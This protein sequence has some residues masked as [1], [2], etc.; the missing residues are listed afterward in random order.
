MLKKENIQFIHSK[1]KLKSVAGL[2]VKSLVAKPIRLIFT[3]LLSI[4][5]FAMFGVFDAVGSFNDERAVIAL[6]EGDNYKSVSIYAQYNG[7]GYNEAEFKLSQAQINKINKDTKYSF[8]G[9]YDIKDNA[10]YV[11]GLSQRDNFNESQTISDEGVKGNLR[12]GGDYYTKE[13][14]GIIEF[15]ESEIVNK[16]IAPKEYN[17][18][19][20]YGEYP[21]LKTEKEKYQGVGIS[22]YMANSIFQWLKNNQTDTFGGKTGIKDIKD[23]VG[24]ELKL[25]AIS[26]KRFVI[27]AIIDCG[28]IPEKY[29]RLKDVPEG[30][31]FALSEDFKT[32][33]NSGC[34]LTLFAPEGYVE[35]TRKLNNRKTAYFADYS[36]VDYFGT[37]DGADLPVTKSAKPYYYNVNEFDNTNTILFEDV[38]NNGSAQSQVPLDATEALVSIN[39]LRLLFHYD[40]VKAS[41]SV[42][43]KIIDVT[44]SIIYE[45]T[46]EGRVDKT[47][48]LL[49]LMKEVNGLDYN[50]TAYR[51]AIQI[52]GKVNNDTVS[53]NKIYVKGFYFDANTDY[54]SYSPSTNYYDPFVLSEEGLRNLGV[55]TN[56]GIYS[57]AI[58]AIKENPKGAQT[59][60]EMM[61][62]EDGLCIRWYENS[63]LETLDLNADFINQLLQLFLY[64][65][66]AVIIFSMFMLMNYIT[67]SIA[68]RRHTIGIL[69]ALGAKGK[70]IFAMFLFESLIIALI[71]GILASVVGYVASIFVNGYILE[72]MN[73]TISFALFGLRQVLIILGVSLATGFVSSLIPIIKIIKE[74]PVALIRKDS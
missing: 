68:S 10:E 26:T 35:T 21:K 52:T 29:M 59:L 2:G 43:T 51:K 15:K 49:D 5:A 4:I 7:N 65:S 17:Y 6:L 32:F 60:G 71:N 23:L 27:K 12:N 33:I 25:S 24:A 9:I 61:V 64:I 28:T 54:T 70:N 31:M 58:S 46:Y 36:Q 16:V 50:Y 41:D 63:V 13:F 8:R 48:Q 47:K 3:V 73:M 44:N 1:M 14:N 42:K 67:T 66:L 30:T 20:V 72:I 62:E 11:D 74:K 69:R 57:R 40:L 39:N 55:N 22:Y 19:I 45:T 56:Q 38:E 34:Y 53:S 37:Q 18:Q